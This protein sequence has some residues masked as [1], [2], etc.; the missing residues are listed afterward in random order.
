MYIYNY[1][2][3]IYIYIYKSIFQ[4]PESSLVDF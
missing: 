2:Y 4:N 3:V 1:I